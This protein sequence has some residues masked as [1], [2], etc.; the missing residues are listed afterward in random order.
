MLCPTLYWIYPIEGGAC[1]E[2]H[3]PALPLSRDLIR[4]DALRRSLTLYR[5]AFGQARQED[6]MAFLLTHFSE[7]EALEIARQLQINLE[8]P[9]SGQS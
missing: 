3:I 5:I 7:A 6:I 9:H 2:R 4:S 8:P 1:I